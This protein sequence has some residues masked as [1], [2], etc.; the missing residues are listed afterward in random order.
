MP[1]INFIIKNKKNKGLVVNGRELKTLYFYGIDIVNQQGTQL[2]DVSLETYIRQAQEEIEQYLSI[3]LIPQVIQ[4]TGDY[5]RDEFRGTGFVKTEYIVNKALELD[6]YIGEQ[7]QLSYPEAWLTENKSNGVGTTRQI[8]VVP[9]SNVNT[10][11]INAGL[12]AGATIPYLGL[13]NS[14]SIGS[15]W[16]KKYI[17]GFPFD[18]MPYIL[19]DLVGKYASIRVFNM[20]GD[21]VLGTAGV[22]NMSLSLDGL[23][24]SIGTTA[25]ATAAAYSA[26]IIQYMK[27]IK[28]SLSQLKGVYRGI[29]LTSI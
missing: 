21:I 26:R 3:K 5:Y 9:N 6:G 15:Y 14:N 2:D 27:E 23:S 22:A 12:F 19:L 11:S 25:S 18:S 24:Q 4:E 29:A 7:K 13:V 20:L 1:S 8:I 16:H 28:E 17:T 10:M